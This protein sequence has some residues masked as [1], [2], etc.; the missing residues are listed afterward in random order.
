MAVTGPAYA[1][2]ME[3]IVQFVPEGAQFMA[4]GQRHTVRHVIRMGVE[5]GVKLSGERTD[6]QR[7][8]AEFEWGDSIDLLG[9]TL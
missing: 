6:G 4:R 7:F 1:L 9:D 3:T 8:E 2:R 5:K